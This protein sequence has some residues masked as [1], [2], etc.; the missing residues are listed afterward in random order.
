[1]ISSFFVYNHFDYHLFSEKKL[2][3]NFNLTNIEGYTKRKI[4]SEVRLYTS[5]L[6]DITTILRLPFVF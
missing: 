6:M 5:N 4:Q 2:S 3:E 1:M